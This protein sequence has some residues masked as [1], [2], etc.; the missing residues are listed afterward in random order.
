MSST[1]FTDAFH[2]NRNA[3]KLAREFRGKR[4]NELADLIGVSPSA[5]TQFE[6]GTAKP[7]PSKVAEMGFALGFPR[8]FFRSDFSEN[9]IDPEQCNFR[10]LK[11]STQ[12]ERR[13][14]VGAG[15]IISSVL[16][17]L[18]SKGVV[19]P[20]ETISSRHVNRIF[21]W[22]DIEDAASMLRQHWGLGFGPIGNLVDLLE[23]NGIIV[24]RLLEDC[25]SLDAFST[26][27]RHRPFIFLNTEKGSTSRSRFDAAHEL[28]HLI[29]HSECL[30]GDK[31]HE[32]EANRFAS[33]FLLPR[34][35][36]L[37]ECPRR[38][39]WQ[40]FLELK[41]RWKVSLAA[42]IRR[43]RD[44]ELLSEDTYKRGNVARNKFGWRTNEPNE[45]PAEVPSILTQSVD[46]LTKEGYSISQLAEEANVF[47]TDFRTL[48]FWKAS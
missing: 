14:M 43:A 30:Q 5:I 37:R 15:T 48:L 17:L 10:S 35:T 19:L 23:S 44:L 34:E 20:Q 2:F 4:K 1:T 3:L 7:S 40:H 42:L 38:L 39:I 27:Q 41:A 22:E 12:L 33:A 11:S 29:L 36:F 25:K 9:W 18:E 45:P 6:N 24:A 32:D 31:Q 13:K 16:S 46:L 47:E 8:S 21:S 26:W 28:G